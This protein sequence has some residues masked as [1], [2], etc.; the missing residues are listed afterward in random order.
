MVV[1]GNPAVDRRQERDVPGRLDRV[2]SLYVVK[3]KPGGASTNEEHHDQ[4]SITR[5]W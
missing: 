4:G 3:A 1:L 2:V 5:R